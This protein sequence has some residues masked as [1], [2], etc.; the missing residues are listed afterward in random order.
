MASFAF[1]RIAFQSIAP[2]FFGALPRKMFSAMVRFGARFSSWKIGL[3]PMRCASSVLLGLMFL[4]SKI[5]SPELA[6]R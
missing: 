3:M 6:S 2:C 5:S 4:P 1:S